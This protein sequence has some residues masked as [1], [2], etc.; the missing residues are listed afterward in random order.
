MSIKNVLIDNNS[1][2]IK[3]RPDEVIVT[4]IVGLKIG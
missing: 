3:T 1:S 4:H 2:L